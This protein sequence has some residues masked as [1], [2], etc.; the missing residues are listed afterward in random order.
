[1]LPRLILSLA[2]I[3]AGVLWVLVPVRGPHD[4]LVY[5]A[6]ALGASLSLG[7]V[8]YSWFGHPQVRWDYKLLTSAA[9]GANVFML[10]TV[11]MTR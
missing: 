4:A 6:A 9:V 5:G 3:M 1:M 2:L 10:I 8:F 11:F 7:A